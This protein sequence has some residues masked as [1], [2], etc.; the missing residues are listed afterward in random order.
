MKELFSWSRINLVRQLIIIA[1]ISF[2]A[3]VLA[4]TPPFLNIQVFQS[5]KGLQPIAPVMAGIT[6]TSKCKMLLRTKYYWCL[7]L[8]IL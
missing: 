2:N 3:V 6:G 7:T 8:N 5:Q 1:D 4:Q